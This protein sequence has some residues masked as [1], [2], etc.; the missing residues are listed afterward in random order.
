LEE[1]QKKGAVALFGEKYGENVRVV[2]IGDGFSK[3]LCGGTHV[4]STGQIGYFIIIE[5]TAIA[6]GIRRIEA[7][8]GE[9]AYNYIQEKYINPLEEIKAILK[10]PL[11]ELPDMV[12]SM[13][14]QNGNLRK[15]LEEF[16][17][18]K[19]LAYKEILKQKITT[20]NGINF[21]A[22]QVTI[23]TSFLKD[24]AFAIRNE[25]ENLFLLM[26][27][28]SD[29]KVNLTLMISDNL[30]AEKNWNASQIIREFAKE[31]QGGGGGQNYFATAGGKKAEGL[32]SAFNLAKDFVSK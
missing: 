11:L 10:K 19:A 1:A 13:V 18:E 9:V 12:H 29:D 26:G 6:S 3:E 23:D 21:L 31:I 30:V 22:D 27:N 15:Q 8:T 25:V 28:V 4:K 16:Q 2:T 14:E 17:K 24:L 5:E 20:I 32:E 7:I